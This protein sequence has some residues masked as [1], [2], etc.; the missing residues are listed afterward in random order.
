MDA[1]LNLSPVLGLLESKELRK[2][3]DKA[4]VHLACQELG[5]R[6]DIDK[7]WDIVLDSPDPELVQRSLELLTSLFVSSRFA[8]IG[9][10]ISKRTKN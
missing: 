5:V 3:V 10:P 2:G 8:Y 4:R 9:W 7:E 6:Q 1:L